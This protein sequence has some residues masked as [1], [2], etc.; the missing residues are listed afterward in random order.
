M[1]TIAELGTFLAREKAAAAGPA[2]LPANGRTLASAAANGTASIGT[3]E[4]G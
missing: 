2:L 1:T 4:L 3:G